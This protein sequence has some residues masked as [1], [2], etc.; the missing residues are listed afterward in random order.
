MKNW[1]RKQPGS[2]LISRLSCRFSS[3][4]IGDALKSTSLR[5]GGGGDETTVDVGGDITGSDAEL[6]TEAAAA[7]AGVG[8]FF[9]LGVRGCRGFL[10]TGGVVL[11]TAFSAWGFGFGGGRGLAVGFDS[12]RRTGAAGGWAEL[13]NGN[14]GMTSGTGGGW[15][16]LVR[17]FLSSGFEGR[18]ALNL[19]TWS[20]SAA[21]CNKHAS[22]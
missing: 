11:A 12:V 18:S 17:F 5:R 2:L 14:W 6:T 15:D 3:Y 22:N 8:G 21:S 4:V 9:A 7:A 10:G 16:A 19:A 13:T 1:I 20:C